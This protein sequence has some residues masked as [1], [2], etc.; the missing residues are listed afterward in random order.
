MGK[1]SNRLKKLF[2][3]QVSN[4]VIDIS[5]LRKGKELATENLNSII[6]VE[7]LLE[8]GCT[9]SEAVYINMQN[10]TSVLLED[11]IMLPPASSMY[12]FFSKQESLYE[13][14]Y[15][16]H[17]PITNSYYNLWLQFDA[18]FGDDKESIGSCIFDMADI[19][20]IQDVQLMA[21]KNLC[22]S[23]MGIYE[24][25]KITSE[26]V[27]T[28][29]EFITEKTTSLKFDSHFSGQVGDILYIRILPSLFGEDLFVTLGV[30]YHLVGYSENA[31]KEYF[32]KQGIES[33]SE[34]FQQ[35]FYDHMKYG[36]D[37]NYW[38]EYAFWAYMQHRPDVIYLTGLPDDKTSQAAHQQFRAHLK[39][40]MAYRKIES[41]LIKKPE[42]P[43]LSRDLGV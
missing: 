21:L 13:P 16:P 40:S 24:V 38:V 22:E 42:I 18:A 43:G 20:K 4:K 35:K 32:K 8:Q 10:L 34:N 28:I 12:R 2:Q 31:W 30:P 17:S 15:P 37:R 25:M 14:G 7:A 39:Y 11:L 33:G 29:R 26:R 41:R 3:D 36:K 23:R 19:L 5:A 1:I 9:P 6:S 27:F